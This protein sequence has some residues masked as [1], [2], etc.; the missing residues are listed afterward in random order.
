MPLSY[1]QERLWFL[2]QLGL[3]GLGLQHPP[4]Q[5]RGW[6]GRLEVAAL[7]G[8]FPTAAAAARDTAHAVRARTRALPHQLIEP[9]GAG[10]AWALEVQERPGPVRGCGS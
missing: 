2:E 1:A 10:G 6:Q 9:G 4:L 3:G 8:A 5:L 7:Q